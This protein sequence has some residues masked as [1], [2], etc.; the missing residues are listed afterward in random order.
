MANIAAT[1]EMYIPLTGLDGGKLMMHIGNA[2]MA[3]VTSELLTKLTN[4]ICAIITPEE[5]FAAAGAGIDVYFCDR[6]VSSSRVTIQR[7]VDDPDHDEF[8]FILIGEVY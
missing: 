2:T 7:G 8:Q 1:D 5:Y 3:S 6:L 4:I